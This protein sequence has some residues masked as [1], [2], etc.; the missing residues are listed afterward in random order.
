MSQ[1]FGWFGWG[2]NT[3]IRFC[4]LAEFSPFGKNNLEWDISLF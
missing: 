1:G 3:T 4:V 2:K